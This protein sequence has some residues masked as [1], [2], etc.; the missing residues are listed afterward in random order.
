MAPK[1]EQT[2]LMDE[3]DEEYRQKRARNNVSV[4]KSREK[5]KQREKESLER[6]NHLRAENTELEDQI[7]KLQKEQALLKEMLLSSAGKRKRRRV[8]RDEEAAEIAP[9][10]TISAD[11]LAEEM[12]QNVSFVTD[13]NTDYLWL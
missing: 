2:K 11:I 5:T 9:R 4:Q 6:A 8:V 10:T 1:K 12:P 3:K 7:T 13:F